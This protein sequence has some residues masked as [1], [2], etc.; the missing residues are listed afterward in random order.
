MVNLEH[1]TVYMASAAIEPGLSCVIP[2]KRTGQLYVIVTPD[3]M[4]LI[5]PLGE[6]FSNGRLSRVS[7]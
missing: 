4:S 3:S 6:V 5:V 7:T 2:V 1:L